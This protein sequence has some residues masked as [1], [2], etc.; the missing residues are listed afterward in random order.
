M[1][2]IFDAERQ[3]RV[4]GELEKRIARRRRAHAAARFLFAGV[5][6]L[7][8]GWL[9]LRTVTAKAESEH[10]DSSSIVTAH[11]G[12]SGAGALE[13]ARVSALSEGDGGMRAD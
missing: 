4:W 12:R 1:S 2:R 13:P 11:D 3:R 7:A 5:G 9:L 10:D 6:T 8:I